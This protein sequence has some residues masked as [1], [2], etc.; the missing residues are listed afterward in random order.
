MFSDYSFSIDFGR[1]QRITHY[2]YDQAYVED[3]FL[4]MP[5]G[6]F[7][8]RNSFAVGIE[9]AIAILLWGK[10]AGRTLDNKTTT[11]VVFKDGNEFTFFIQDSRVEIGKS[12][13][14]RS[15]YPMY[16]IW[17]NGKIQ[18]VKKW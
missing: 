16:L 12:I 7:D 13:V 9:N 5:R 18:R 4:T 17:E 6:S 1:I 15:S 10:E 14:Q 3:A 8:D 11:Q 2:F